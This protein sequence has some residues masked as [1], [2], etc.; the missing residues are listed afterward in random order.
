M[1]KEKTNKKTKKPI[2]HLMGKKEFIFDF[3]SLV[4]ALSVVLY[5]GGRCFY[6][7]SLQHQSRKDHLMS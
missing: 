2:K 4:F 7:Y 1:V 3:I 5:Y 6:Y